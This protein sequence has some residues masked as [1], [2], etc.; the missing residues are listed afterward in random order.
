MTLIVLL[1]TRK[2]NPA[3]GL[4]GECH[5]EPHSESPGL[6][7]RDGQD[8]RY[9]RRDAPSTLTSTLNTADDTKVWDYALGLSKLVQHK[10]NRLQSGEIN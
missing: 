2:Q 1:I 9:F 8:V 3:R 5:G 4:D 10:E 7:A 6:K